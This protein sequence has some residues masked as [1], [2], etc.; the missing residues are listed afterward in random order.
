MFPI[1]P[2]NL[3]ICWISAKN[4]GRLREILTFDEST[5][6]ISVYLRRGACTLSPMLAEIA[7]ADSTTRR[8]DQP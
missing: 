1:R 2:L 5:R 6:I 4:C 7:A 3:D 8:Y